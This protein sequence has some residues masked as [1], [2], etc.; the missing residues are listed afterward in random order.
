[1][2][3]AIQDGRFLICDESEVTCE[4]FARGCETIDEYH[5]WLEALPTD[6][7]GRPKI[8]A[9]PFRLIRLAGEL[10][11]RYD[12]LLADGYETREIIYKDKSVT[13]ETGQLVENNTVNPATDSADASAVSDINTAAE[14]RASSETLLGDDEARAARTDPDLWREIRAK[15]DQLL[16]ESDKFMIPDFPIESSEREAWRKYRTALRDITKKTKRPERIR[17]PVRP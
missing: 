3:V 15:R 16:Q 13:D 12:Q 10:R 17:W 5:D 9:A 2:Y 11:E 1:M 8:P 7:W 4:A 6:R 14:S